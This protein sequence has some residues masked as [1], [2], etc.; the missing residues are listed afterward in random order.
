LAAATATKL[1]RIGYHIAAVG[2]GPAADWTR[3]QVRYPPGRLAAAKTLAGTLVGGAGLTEDPSLTGSFL[4]LVL[5]P[6]FSGV[7]VPPA[8]AGAGATAARPKAARP[9]PPA[10]ELRE[11]DPRPC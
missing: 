7:R 5:G 6:G 10:A 1:R 4:T 8:G 2:N 11:Y 3:S 9:R